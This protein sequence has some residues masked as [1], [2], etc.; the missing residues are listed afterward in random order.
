[1]GCAVYQGKPTSIEVRTFLERTIRQ[2]GTTPPHLICDKGSQFWC[3]DFK[4]WCKRRD[5]KPRYGA[6]GRHGSIAIVERFIRTM[7]QEGTRRMFV[8]YAIFSAS[9]RAEGFVDV[10]F[11]QRSG[12]AGV[13]DQIANRA[14]VVGEGPVRRAGGAERSDFLDREELVDAFAPEVAAFQFRRC[15]KITPKTYTSSS[16][17]VPIPPR[18]LTTGRVRSRLTRWLAL[19][20]EGWVARLFG[21][22]ILAELLTVESIPV[23]FNLLFNLATRQGTLQLLYPCGCHLGTEQIQRNSPFQ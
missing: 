1:M 17:T 3:D 23:Q 8:S 12:I 5:I 14:E 6:V 19:Q 20:R 15:C 11:L 9:H 2:A 21:Q 18:N 16:V 22:L 7:K 4:A 13:G 10:M